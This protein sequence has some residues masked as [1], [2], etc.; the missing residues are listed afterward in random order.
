MKV[1]SK[2]CLKRRLALLE[3]ENDQLQ[4]ELH[5]LDLILKKLGFAFGLETVK[6][7]AR[8]ILREGG[9]ALGGHG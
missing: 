5:E 2:V 4:A 8:E 6:E 3:S 7:A 9:N 1:I